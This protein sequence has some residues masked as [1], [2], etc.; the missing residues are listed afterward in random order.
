MG[1]EPGVQVPPVVAWLLAGLFLW[2]GLRWFERANLYPASRSPSGAHPGSFGWPYEELELAAEDGPRL[3]A[4]WI[5]G[6][7]EG[8]VV[9][10][11]HGN[12]GNISHRFDKLGLFRRA[13]ASVLIYDYRGY[14]RS[15]GTPS[16]QGTYRDGE[17]AW[18]WLTREKRIPPERVVLY[19]ESLG[20]A[21]AL[22]LALREKPAGL[23]L[24]SP[25][26]STIAMGQE[27]FP[28]LPVRW[29][30]RYRYDNLSKIAK[31]SAPLLV[32][33]SPEDDIVPYAM[34]RRL[35]E[36]APA[37]KDFFEMKGNHNDGFADTG[38]AYGEA[39]KAFLARAV[40]P[41]KP[42]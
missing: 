18:R 7:P 16:E 1:G 32:M 22:E 39:L 3:H 21:I 36:A 35:F 24:D 13:G 34:G 9:L 30:V 27:I 23:I 38:P 15:T 17:A 6:P 5:P 41:R 19:G 40:P 25:F 14:G 28:F 29:L 4:W 11:S 33:H 31:L 10:F 12:G 20:S 8:P 42:R 2:F 26:T 37:P